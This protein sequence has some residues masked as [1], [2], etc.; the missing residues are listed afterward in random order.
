MFSDNTLT[1]KEAIRLCALGSLAG[2]PMSYS[3]LAGAIRHFVSRIM[4]PSLEVMGTSIE[5]LKL[6]GLVKAD[7]AGDGDL[8]R[9]TDDGRKELR[10]LLAANVRAATTDLNKLV[11]ALKFRFMHLLDDAERRAQ[12]DLLVD[13]CER[14]LA[15]L[16][17]LRGH[18]PDGEGFLAEWLDHDIELLE[19]RL[20]WLRDFRDRHGAGGGAAS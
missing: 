5:L 13:V 3:Q 1:P 8:L 12:A 16:E 15:R 6:E 9:I 4:G 17:D 19:M 18:D 11:V 14:E 20:K 10:T 2:H 7:G